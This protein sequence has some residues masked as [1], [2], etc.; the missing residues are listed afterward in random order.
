MSENTLSHAFV[1]EGEV[2]MTK[3]TMGIGH[4]T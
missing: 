4:I 1:S 3:H 2:F